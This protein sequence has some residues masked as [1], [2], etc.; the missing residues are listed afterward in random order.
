MANA[1]L[2]YTANKITNNRLK[3]L[4]TEPKWLAWGTGAGTHTRDRTTL[5]TEA[6]EARVECTTAVVTITQASD[7]F[8]ASGQ[9]TADGV[10]VITNIGI[11]DQQAVGGDPFA[12][13]DFTGIPV[14]AG[15]QIAFVITVQGK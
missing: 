1:V 12:L 8:R 6:S 11:F 9:M 13:A 5:F 15:S 7:G 3:G 2:P 4:G 10:K 14:V